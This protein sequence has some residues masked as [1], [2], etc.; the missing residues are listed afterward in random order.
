LNKN[1]DNR[2]LSLIREIQETPGKA[3]VMTTRDYLL[4]HARL[5][6]DRLVAQDVSEAV[7]VIQLTDLGLRVRGQILYNHVHQSQLPPEEKR[8]FADPEVWCLVVEHRN[9]NPRLI[10]ETLRLSARRGQDVAAAMLENLDDPRRVW[11]RIVENELSDEAV[12]LL[13]VLFTFGSTGLGSLEASWHSY[14]KEMDQSADGRTFRRAL[15]VLDGTMVSVER[16][17]VT[18]HNPSIEDYVRFHLDAG[19]ARLADLLKALIYEEQV[20]RLIGAADIADGAGILA[21]LREHESAVAAIIMESEGPETSL[22]DE[23]ESQSTH[24]QWVLETADLLNSSALAAYVMSETLPPFTYYEY[25]SHLESLADSLSASPLI[26]KDYA[27]RFRKEVAESIRSEVEISVEAGDWC[28]SIALRLATPDTFQSA[29]R[30]GDR[31]PGQVR[32]GGAAPTSHAAGERTAYQGPGTVEG[33]GGFPH[34][35][36]RPG[37]AAGRVRH[38][39][40]QG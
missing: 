29:P 5:R 3:L 27:E 18:F 34:G 38:R 33:A 24:L 21:W 20:H 12:H 32:P 26:P 8:R 25:F 37:R 9:F 2:L 7:S 16:G 1:E 39:L 14:R 6:H 35:A 23:D 11:E 19:R 30:T 22:S 28:Q 10:E 40:Q 15:Q 31:G 13:E 36:G 17:Q 4:E